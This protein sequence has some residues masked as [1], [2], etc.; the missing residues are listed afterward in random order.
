MILYVGQEQ[1]AHA[2][3]ID[4]HIFAALNSKKADVHGK[5]NQHTPTQA[6]GHSAQRFA[7]CVL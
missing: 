6:S 1:Q 2:E 7:L 4:K 3:R 5:L